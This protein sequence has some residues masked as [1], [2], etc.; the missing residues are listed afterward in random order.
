MIGSDWQVRG[1]SDLIWAPFQPDR[2]GRTDDAERAADLQAAL[3]DDRVGAIV[4]LRGGAWLLRI[5]PRIDFGVLASRRKPVML[6]GFSEWT[7]LAVVAVQYPMAVCIHHTAPLYMVPGDPSQPLSSPQKRTRWREIWTSIGRILRGQAPDLPLSGRLI[8]AGA[9]LNSGGTVTLCGGNLTLLAA[10]AGTPYARAVRAAGGWLALEDINESIGQID[11][12]VA[13]LGLAGL[14]DGIGGVLLGSF[15]SQGRNLSL[16][17]AALLAVHLPPEVPVVADCN[18]G[19]DWPA[20]PLPLGRPV[21]L[22][23]QPDRRVHVEIDWAGGMG[24]AG[25]G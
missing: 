10:L 13:Q 8:E 14:L 12:K 2:A 6:F 24:G 17:V 21:R 4:A 18:F 9:G 22:T 7:C 3:A 25:G 1:R 5:L 11:R 23:V 19:H 15:H 16:D 20:A